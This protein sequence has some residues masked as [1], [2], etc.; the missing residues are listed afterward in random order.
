MASSSLLL[1]LFPFFFTS[2]KATP[3]NPPPPFPPP[4]KCTDRCGD[5]PLP[6]PF[7]LTDPSCGLNYSAFQLTCVDSVLYLP[8]GGPRDLRVVRFSSDGSNSIVLDFPSPPS[9]TRHFVLESVDLGDA[10]FYGLSEENVLRLYDCED[11]SVC[12]TGRCGSVAGCDGDGGCC[13][14]LSDRDVWGPGEN[15]S[16]FKEFGCRGFSSWVKGGNSTTGVVRGIEIEW[17]VPI[18]SQSGLCADGASV[19]NVTA[20]RDGVRCE[21]GDGY[22]GDGFSVGT[23]CLKS[24]INGG[25]V[26]YGEGCDSESHGKKKAA[27]LA[28][29]LVSAFSLV[30]LAAICSLARWIRNTNKRK[31][32]PPCI[33]EFRKACWTTSFSYRELEQATGGFE[34]SQKLVHNATDGTVHAAVLSNGLTVV[35]QKVKC[36]GEQDL[37]LL[38]NRVQ[39]LS[40]I[41]HRNIARFLGCCTELH[42][43][44][45]LVYESPQNGTLD[46][47]LRRQNGTFINW[48]RRV[49]I[50]TEAAIALSYLQFGL[51]PPLYLHDIKSSDIYVCGNYSIK[52][53]G[54]RLF[55]SVHDLARVPCDVQSFGVVLLELLMGI[56]HEDTTEKALLMIKG[57]NL[58]EITDPLLSF[59]ELPSVHQEQIAKIRDLS[60]RC[61]SYGGLSMIEVAREL[62]QIMREDVDN[63]GVGRPP[64]EETF[65]NSSLLQMI[66]MSPDSMLAT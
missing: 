48:Y 19:V 43:T 16:V 28:G 56:N 8:L 21:C 63:V 34:E 5:L 61:L 27:V 10:G 4:S 9:C 50:A 47:H 12:K 7:H 18:G 38:L 24:C 6:F 51:S 59:H 62:I 25:H 22:V 66:S 46:E 49:S 40:R 65:S 20:V 1:L 42:Y 15:F 39:S 11:S 17:A 60:V 54:F 32:G 2:F 36:E 31:L 53:A 23:G 44:L 30:A 64:L 33:V 58:D 14:P 3:T 35:V 13:Y 52:I 57:R 55:R 26:V 37:I 45:F 29:A 41:T